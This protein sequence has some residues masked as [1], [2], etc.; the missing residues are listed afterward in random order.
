MKF[1][2]LFD[3]H[4][5]LAFEKQRHLAEVVGES[6]WRFDMSAGMLAFDQLELSIQILGTVSEYSNTW[7]WAWANTASRIPDHLLEAS[8]TLQAI[9]KEL[10][11]FELTEPELHVE[12]HSKGH[13]L[14]M[15]A[16]GLLSA[17]AYYRGPYDGGAAFFLIP[18][19]PGDAASGTESP[20]L[21]LTSAFTDFISAFECHQQTA[22]QAYAAAKGYS[23]RKSGTCR[24]VAERGGQP[25]VE[26]LFD[27][28]G[29]LVE[30][31]T[32]ITAPDAV[33]PDMKPWWKFW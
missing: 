33:R 4:G 17:A 6:S 14:A 16:T 24:V 26:T 12:N 27:S 19:L 23:C 20:S 22:F 1:E 25:S 10:Q 30:I 5:A 8:R 11:A 18:K 28:K 15:V 32:Q 2:D 29:R 31:S 3:Q 21:Q 13:L 9:G 7:L